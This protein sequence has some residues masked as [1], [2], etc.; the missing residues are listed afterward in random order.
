VPVAESLPI[1]RRHLA[2]VQ[3]TLFELNRLV[4]SARNVGVNNWEELE[5]IQGAI[6]VSVDFVNRLAHG[7]RYGGH[8][9]LDGTFGIWGETTNGIGTIISASTR[10]RD[11][12][13]RVAVTA[14]AARPSI[15]SLPNRQPL[16][17]DEIL[18]VNS[19]SITLGAGS[20]L[21][22]QITRINQFTSQ[23]NVIAVR[24]P[25]DAIRLLGMRF[26]APEP[27]FVVSNRSASMGNSSG[28]GTGPQLVFGR[29][30][31]L[32]PSAPDF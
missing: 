18:S 24:T 27:L 29:D 14:P 9:L 15:T 22:D 11:D 16:G 12:D 23:T 30:V 3:L 1:A 21:E 19:V 25:L 5:G 28:F 10:S 31:E 17:Y 8:G 20:S 13:F 4:N 32:D 26:G 2:S 6:S 7:A